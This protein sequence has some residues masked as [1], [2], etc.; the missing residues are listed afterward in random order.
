MRASYGRRHDRISIYR[1][2]Q[3]FPGYVARKAVRI[4]KTFAGAGKHPGA[5]FAHRRAIPYVR[6]TLIM[7][8]AYDAVTE[9]LELDA[10]IGIDVEL[11]PRQMA[12]HRVRRIGGERG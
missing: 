8:I 10:A 1:I 6:Q 7:H 9:A 4:A 3:Q 5:H 2:S 11:P 12:K